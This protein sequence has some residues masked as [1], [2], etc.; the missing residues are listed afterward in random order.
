MSPDL[1]ALIAKGRRSLAV[2]KRLCAEGDFDFS[3]SRAYYAMFYLTEALLLSRS[4]SFSKHS[5][6]IAEFHREFVRPGAFS[7]D[8]YA[9]LQKAFQDRN[10]GDYQYRETFPAG[11]AQAVLERAEAFV[12]DAEGY[13]RRGTR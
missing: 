13:L 6:V 9:A 8:H 7:Y 2:A 10:I 11:R 4:L 3:A 12:N 1:E 5:A